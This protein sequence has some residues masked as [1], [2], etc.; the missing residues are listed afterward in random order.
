MNIPQ[1]IDA[2]LNYFFDAHGPAARP[3]LLLNWAFSAISLAV[4]AIIA[5]LLLAAILHR[6][7]EGDTEITRRGEGVRFIAIGTGITICALLA[8][9]IYM[10]VTLDNVARPPREPALTI[11]VTGYDWWWK[12]EYGGFETANELHIP[13]GVPVLIE[14]ESADVI[15]AF[16]VPQLAGKTE[17]IPG[18]TNRQWLQADKPGIYRGQCTQFCGAQHAHMAFEVVAESPDDF[19]AW[20]EAQRKSAFPVT[21]MAGQRIFMDNCASCHAVRGTKATG[22]H[23]PD[24]TH[25]GSRRLLAA[26]L[27]TNT[28]EH[29]MDWVRSA[30]QLKPGSR[31]PDFAFSPEE[32]DAL[33][34]YLATLK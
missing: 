6:R 16:W 22:G 20:Q 33:S 25:L 23:A 12:A 17:M 30:Q 19:Q 31:M 10:L 7:P 21:D 15:H 2:P 3:T 9:T 1:N 4:C 18:M 26:G 11:K 28:P 13:V 8:M 32:A 5:F 27:I 34:A 24:L 29:I 14:L